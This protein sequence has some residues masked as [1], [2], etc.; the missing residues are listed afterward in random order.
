MSPDD[1]DYRIAGGKQSH[2]GWLFAAGALILAGGLIWLSRTSIAD[3]LVA[4]QLKERGVSAR[5][6]IE[7]IGPR[8][9]RITNVVIGDAARPDLVARWVELDIGWTWSGPRVS[10]IRA[11]GVRLF[12]KW[13]QGRLSFGEVDKLLPPPS[14]EPF[15]IPD[16]ALALTDARA[17]IETPWGPI[18]T[19]VAGSG[20]LR[21]GFSGE[22]A[23]VGDALTGGGC[24]ADRISAFGKI[25]VEGGKPRFNGPVRA[26][27]I[28]C[29]DANIR[30]ARF[31]TGLDA[32]L[33]ADFLGWQ[34]DFDS[35]ASDI[36]VSG[37]RLAG[38]KVRGRFKGSTGANQIDFAATGRKLSFADAA[39]QTVEANG[40]V[41]VS[42]EGRA[43]GQA[44]IAFASGQAPPSW[45]RQ[46]QTMA[47]SDS[48]APLG[49]L[50]A[51][52]SGAGLRA[53]DNLS[54]QAELRLLSDTMSQQIQI[55]GLTLQSASGAKLAASSTNLLS[56]EVGDT[57]RW[58]AKGSWTLSGG[59][60]PQTQ[61]RLDRSRLGAL[62]A[63]IRL[64][65]LKGRTSRLALSPI[66]LVG[67]PGGAYQIATQAT[68]S[69][70]LAGGRFSGLT[71]PVN[72]VV[73]TNGDVRLASGCNRLTIESANI[74]GASFGP[75]ALKLCG[76]PG[77][78]MLA[79]RDGQW[80][81]AVALVAPQLKGR[82]GDS[83]LVLTATGGSYALA[84]GKWSLD[85]VTVAVG[86]GDAA[87]NFLAMRIDGASAGPSLAGTIAEVSGEIGTIPLDLQQ[88]NGDWRFQDATLTVA[89][90]LA[91]S[92][93]AIPDRFHPLAS[94]DVNLQFS[95]GRITA[96]ANFK[97]VDTG[98]MIGRV[99]LRHDFADASG[100][101]DL[102]VSALQFGPAF[103]PEQL[104][105][106]ALGVIANA[107]AKLS[108]NGRIDWQG[109]DVRS[110]GVFAIDAEKFAA[111][112]GTVDGAKGTIVFDDLLAMHSPPGQIFQL[113]EVNPGFPVVGGEIS[114]QLLD[115][116][117]IHIEGGRWPFAGGELRLR[118]T[119]LDFDV[120][121]VRRLEFELTG[122]DAAVFLTELGFDNI[123]AS[124][125]FDGVLPVEFSGLGGRIVGGRLSARP[126][127][128]EVAY[129]GELSNYNLG[130]MAN[131]AFN[132]LKS[133]RYAEM[134]ITLDG[135]LDG[136]M[137]TEIQFK[138]LRQGTGASRNIITRQIEK[139]PIIFNVRINAPFRELLGSAK[140]LYDPTDF[141]RQ[142]LPGLIEAQ[143]QQQKILV[144]PPESDKVP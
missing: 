77:Q 2:R 114:Y 13:D 84:S 115:S 124:G 92:D 25:G 65:P 34:G 10:A 1:S 70:N 51:S 11:D 30:L 7:S 91:V 36:R 111:A 5:Y 138:G 4:D 6:Q 83:P 86:E 29:S 61:L 100:S 41:T 27:K 62:R 135:D 98:T 133:L 116:N 72:A 103:Q 141:L 142:R 90:A 127:G 26:A 112:F 58:T 64:A 79:Y 35:I 118:E 128:G 107:D 122:V 117:R 123:N 134:E 73:N 45:R 47:R 38:A 60:L 74:A 67:K 12:G 130:T 54:G 113:D 108:G 48:Q 28:D 17:R 8:T 97:E 14:D 125:V 99:D 80:N 21:G 46:L 49:D 119:T 139:L 101:A 89:G 110:S 44:R 131:F 93:Q 78:P 85:K 42:K 57:L 55:T 106:L 9:Q 96:S 143:R 140:S 88:I 144:Q 52:L 75:N 19:H 81:G 71:W 53:F 76:A 37:G 23:L 43:D 3:N 32:S 109:S 137:L 87:T 59:G 31:E 50:I 66:L 69:G 68:F 24:S 18:G 63:E 33:S 16:W 82:T 39:A 129:V 56:V 120:N 105:P 20:R 15:V 94:D 40:S 102:I 121:A 132:M 22:I 95:D 104:T 136:E 126:G